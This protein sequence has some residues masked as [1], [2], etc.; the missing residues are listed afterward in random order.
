MVYTW[1]KGH[2]N[3]RKPAEELTQNEKLNI[4]MDALAME[5][6]LLPPEMLSFRDSNI[7]SRELWAVFHN[8]SKITSGLKA[9]LFKAF[10]EATVKFLQRKYGFTNPIMESLGWQYFESLFKKKTA[11]Q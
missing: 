10:Q 5:A 1:V 9:I 2:K 6:H 3:M 7:L 4:K 8:G 11:H